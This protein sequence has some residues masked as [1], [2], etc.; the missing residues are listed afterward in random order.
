MLA[1]LVVGSLAFALV[2]SATLGPRAL[3]I[4]LV[5]LALVWVVARPLG[6]HRDDF[7]PAIAILLTSIG[8]VVI[9]RVDATLA[10]R[11]LIWF[12]LALGL[13][14][15]IGPALRRY[16]VLA[17][18]K[19]VWI[20]ASIVLFVL[21]ALFGQEVNGAKLWIR[22]GSLQFE[23]IEAIKL[24]VVLF[25]AA[26]LAETADV[27]AAARPWSLRANVKYLGPLFI[28][29]GTSVGILVFERDIGTAALLLGIFAAMLYVATRRLDLVIGSIAV[30]SLAAW[31]A[32]HHYSYVAAR[33]AAWRYPF[34]DPYGSGYQSLQAL[35]GLGAGGL[36]GTGYGLG[37]PGYI[38]AVAT[39]YVY[40]AFSEEF[41]A[42]AGI[43][44]IALFL[45]LVLRAL[46]VAR[47]K[48]DLYGRLLATGL[49]ATLGFQVFIIVGGVLHLFPLT[50]ITL[51][52]FSYGGSSLVAN[53]LL[54]AFLWAL[55]AR[56][57]AQ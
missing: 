32:M 39:D 26:Y 17:R 45:V 41:G 23:P 7:I 4:A 40:A 34:A 31:W 19:Y 15:V 35:F 33:I 42:L 55:S 12:T 6:E 57:S 48:P 14:I 53:Y 54:V 46:T 2:P 49:A 51:P 29:W 11:Q 10:Q 13:A 44:V 43:A 52:F 38:P 50:G 9:A 30:F 56:A 25:M 27:I 22:V 36:F 24:F 1:A 47:E 8:L 16:R 20:L 3:L 21:V 28:G 37:K 18:Y 5:I